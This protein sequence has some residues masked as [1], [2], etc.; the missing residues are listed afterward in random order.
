[1]INNFYNN[2]FKR[3]VN[4]LLAV[5]FLSSFSTGASAKA[6]CLDEEENHLVDQNF[7]LADCHSSV[8]AD[9]LLSD[10]HYSAQAEKEKNACVDVS[11]T[12]AHIL[13]RPK[14]TLPGFA[15]TIFSYTLPGSI[16]ESQQQVSGYNSAALSRHL[17]SL[18]HTH[19]HRTVVLLI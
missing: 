19:S 2:T 10:E 5:V 4:L 7:Y 14:V 15:R 3:L 9:L 1:M 17:F 8:D 18:A 6:L 11:L 13:N 16:I 12:N